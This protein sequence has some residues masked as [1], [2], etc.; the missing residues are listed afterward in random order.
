MAEP[1]RIAREVVTLWLREHPEI[2][3]VPIAALAVAQESLEVE[4]DRF[5]NQVRPEREA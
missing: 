3:G 5:T 2:H 1:Q 4:P